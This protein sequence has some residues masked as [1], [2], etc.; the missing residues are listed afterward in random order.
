MRVGGRSS[1]GW[2]KAKGSGAGWPAP[3][4][5]RLPAPDV[6]LELRLPP[7]WEERER[8]CRCVF[9]DREDGMGRSD[10]SKGPGF[11]SVV[12]AAQKAV[13]ARKYGAGAGGSCPPASF[14][15]EGGQAKG[16]ERR[17]L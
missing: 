6:A 16:R 14:L 11:S 13:G 17:W 10:S 9:I 1:G 8:G 2:G 5:Q 12:T 15:S 4:L 7:E 3:P